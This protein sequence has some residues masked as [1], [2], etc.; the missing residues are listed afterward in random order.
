MPEMKTTARKSTGGTAERMLLSSTVDHTSVA[1]TQDVDEDELEHNDCLNIPKN[2]Q[3]AVTAADVSFICI[4]CHVREQK[5]ND[6]PAPYFGFYK[7]GIPLLA[8]FLPILAAVEVSLKGEMSAVPVLFLHL[9]L[10]NFDATSGP[11]ELAYHFLEPYFP[12]GGLQY[13]EVTFDIATQSKL[14]TYEQDVG[15]LLNDLL[16]QP[17]WTRVVIAITNHSDSDSGDL[18]AGYRGKNYISAT[19]QNFLDVLFKP[20][21]ALLDR[22]QESYLWLF[23]CGALVNKPKS[24]AA[25]RTWVDR[26]PI[27]AAIAFTAVRF[28]PGFTCH[29]L[30][31]FAELVLIERWEIGIAFPHMLGQSNRLGRHTDIV[32][33]LKKNRELGSLTVVK[34]SWANVDNRPWG[35]YLPFQCPGCGWAQ[36]WRSASKAR[37]YTYECKNDHCGQTFTFHQPRG[38]KMLPQGKTGSS[39]WLSIPLLGRP[40]SDSLDPARPTTGG[41][42]PAGTVLLQE[43]RTSA[44]VL[45]TATAPDSDSSDPARPTTGG[46]RPA[47]TVLLQEPLTSFLIPNVRAECIIKDE[48]KLF[49]Y[50]QPEDVDAVDCEDDEVTQTCRIPVFQ[51][52]SFIG[53]VPLPPRYRAVW[54]QLSYYIVVYTQMWKLWGAEAKSAKRQSKAKTTLLRQST[55]ALVAQHMT[56]RLMAVDELVSLAHDLSTPRKERVR[57]LDE[58]KIRMDRDWFSKTYEQVAVGGA[59]FLSIDPIRAENRALFDAEGK[60]MLLPSEDVLDWIDGEV[61]GLDEL[62]KTTLRKQALDSLKKPDEFSQTQ[63]QDGAELPERWH[64]GHSPAPYLWSVKQWDWVTKGNDIRSRP[65]DLLFCCLTNDPTYT[66]FEQFA[67]VLNSLASIVIPTPDFAGILGLGKRLWLGQVTWKDFVDDFLDNHLTAGDIGTSETSEQLGNP[68]IACLVVSAIDV[69]S[70]HPDSRNTLNTLEVRLLLEDSRNTLNTLEV[71]LLLEGYVRRQRSK[72]DQPW[73]IRDQVL[74]QAL[75]RALPGKDHSDVLKGIIWKIVSG[76]N[77]SDVLNALKSNEKKRKRSSR[78]MSQRN[79]RSARQERAEEVDRVHDSDGGGDTGNVGGQG[80]ASA[81]LTSGGDVEMQ[82]DNNPDVSGSSGEPAQDITTGRESNEM[83]DIVRNIPDVSTDQGMLPPPPPPPPTPP[84]ISTPPPIT[85]RHMP[86]ISTPPPA[87]SISTPPPSPPALYADPNDPGS[88]AL[89]HLFSFMNHRSLERYEADMNAEYPSDPPGI[90]KEF[91]EAIA[92]RTGSN[93]SRPDEFAHL[94]GALQVVEKRREAG[95]MCRNL[96]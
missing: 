84:Q 81:A 68:V 10:V 11:F 36:A 14:A 28:Q 37:V 79:V 21:K 17:R 78:G 71:R 24:S 3:A 61:Y 33:M 69:Q 65:I 35:Q 30:L 9:K 55:G 1:Q 50:C 27:T 89:V 19:V 96:L 29:L 90:I 47:G 58:W 46:K 13:Q 66:E 40:Y 95:E 26:N 7:D 73:N 39:C 72:P 63:Y 57:I 8:E 67:Q 88:V 62:F 74:W 59:Q 76:Q 2:C 91:V 80:Q 48:T 60:E 45:P 20:W 15:K 82:V 32:L 12:R 31:A 85:T 86:P 18:F 77:V 6:I 75:S 23:C 64:E 43:P 44:R 41:K 49:K 92:A 53:Y 93:H 4:V 54:L 5:D 51:G 83:E 42:R 16:P 34:F 94:S 38:S 52:K 22:A 87:P 56:A 70:L 25:L